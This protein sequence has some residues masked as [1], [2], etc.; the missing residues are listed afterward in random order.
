MAGWGIVASRHLQTSNVVVG[1]IDDV[2]TGKDDAVWPQLLDVH[3]EQSVQEYCT[4]V[5]RTRNH[6]LVVSDVLHLLGWPSDKQ[7]VNTLVTVVESP[8]S[9]NALDPWA[10]ALRRHHCSLQ[11]AVAANKD[12]PSLQ[13]VADQAVYSTQSIQQL[14]EQLVVVWGALVEAQGIDGV[15]NS[16]MRVA[17]VPWVS[18]SQHKALLALATSSFDQTDA[19]EPAVE[20]LPEKFFQW[21]AQA[22]DQLAVVD[23]DFAVTYH[24]L[25]QYI[26]CLASAMQS[27][28]RV[29]R[30]TR[31]AFLGHRSL[32]ST[33]AMMATMLAGG[34]IVPI[35]RQF[36]AD[37]VAYILH[38]SGCQVLLTTAT[39]AAQ[40]PAEFQGVVVDV[41]NY[42][43]ISGALPASLASVAL[44][45]Q[46]LAYIIYTS[47]TTGRPKG[48]MV[49]YGCLENAV[50]QSALTKCFQPGQV[51]LQ[52]FSV[53]FDPHL[54]MLFSALTHGCTL[55]IMRDEDALGDVQRVDVAAVT[56]SF[57]ARIDPTS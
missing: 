9:E 10:K 25:S 23:G 12:A 6:A 8:L 7:L 16:C 5:E 41:D 18:Q 14:G 35:D 52:F 49:E 40:V 19:S 47:G 42:C 38:D 3:A 37:R 56:P 29:T 21:C 17:E 57:L 32:A 44:A 1:L 46:D 26:H 33:V 30:E 2:C 24:Q 53:A 45:P 34:A 43:S 54:F 55:R 48:V 11:L 4:S 22:P 15:G 13:L 50:L 20:A 39:A 27:Q 31:V 28:H 36:P 51:C